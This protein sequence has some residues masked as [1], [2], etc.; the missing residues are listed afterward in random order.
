MVR[1]AMY[2]LIVKMTVAAGRREEAIAL[3]RESS[4]VM[5]GCVSYVIA[6][7]AAS[8]DV[9]WVTEVWES[10]AAHDGSLTL[11]AVQSVIPRLRPLV[12]QCEKIAVTEP[13]A[14]AA[15]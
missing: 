15:S 7:D 14:G 9:L 8:A 5:P 6:R 10:E 12:A 3:L 11:R 1:G 4:A 13:V 2:G